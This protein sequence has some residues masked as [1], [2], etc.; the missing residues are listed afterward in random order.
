MDGGE[1]G[2]LGSTF[3]FWGGGGMRDA[4]CP[5]IPY[6]RETTHSALNL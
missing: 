5:Q 3:G 6:I 2:D 4:E 1:G